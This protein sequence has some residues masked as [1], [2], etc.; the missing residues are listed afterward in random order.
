L[1]FE[2]SRRDVELSEA[3]EKLNESQLAAD[4]RTTAKP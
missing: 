2:L 3:R 4:F 1:N